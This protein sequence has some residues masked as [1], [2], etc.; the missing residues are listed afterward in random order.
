MAVETRRVPLDGI[1]YQVTLAGDGPP[2]LLLH[3]FTGSAATWTPLLGALA[4]CCRVIAVDLPGHGGSDAP[5]DIRHYTMERVVHDLL[6]LCDALAPAPRELRVLGYSMGGRVALRLALA[7][8]WRIAALVLEGASPGIM[9]PAE[10]AARVATDRALADRIEREG[11]EAFVQYWQALPLF[12]SQQRLPAEARVALRAQRL[13]NRPHG[14]ANSLRGMGAG[15]QEPLAERLAELSMP[16]LLIA[17]DLDEK[18]RAAATAM[19]GRIPGARA[20]IVPDA[21]H[22]VHLEQPAAFEQAVT[23]LIVATVVRPS[24]PCG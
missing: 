19:A 17:G 8:P 15:M 3:G 1:T 13:A 5:E 11:M 4:R 23:E 24:Y 10:R 2:L 20:V 18:Y 12:A 9:D 7:A 14:L 6:A 21:G 16:V 22:T